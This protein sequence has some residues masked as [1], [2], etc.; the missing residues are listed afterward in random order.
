MVAVTLNAPD[1]WQDHTALLDYGFSRYSLVTLAEAGEYR[2]SFSCLGGTSEEVIAVNTDTVQIPLPLEHEPISVTAEGNRYI[3]A[4]VCRGDAIG[5]LTIRCGD[6]VL[7]QIPLYAESDIEQLPA[8][9][10]A[11]DKIKDLLRIS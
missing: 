6:T 4:P 10:S 1:D 5:T 11:A 7:A 3:C 2:I 8:R 9:R